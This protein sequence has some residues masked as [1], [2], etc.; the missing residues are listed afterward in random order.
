MKKKMMIVCLNNK[1]NNSII[2]L[3]NDPKMYGVMLGLITQDGRAI[4]SKKWR[5]EGSE[6]CI[7]DNK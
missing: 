2:L 3:I 1:I 7:E 5:C 4:R 6:A